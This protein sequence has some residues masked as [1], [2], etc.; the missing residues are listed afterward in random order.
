MGSCFLNEINK[1]LINDG[2]LKCEPEYG[3]HTHHEF[4]ASWGTIFSPLSAL[5]AIEYYFDKRQRPE[6]LWTSAHSGKPQVYDVFREDVVFD[7]VEEFRI[8][9]RIHKEKAKELIA[10][11]D[12]L[13]LAFSMIET[14]L[15][16]DGTEYPLAR[17]PW[18]I[19]PLAAQ[20][21]VLSYEE[22]RTT[23]NQ[24]S[25]LIHTVNPKCNVFIGVDPV[26]LHATHGTDT[27]V[28]ADSRAKAVLVSAIM[29][30]ASENKNLKYVPFYESVHY[31]CKEPWQQ[32]E[33][34]VNDEAIMK[35]YMELLVAI[36]IEDISQIEVKGQESRD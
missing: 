21:Y 9:N 36:D 35:A 3:C 19:N 15:C 8:N 22:V 26:P 5:R 1:R 30:C 10:S 17:A 12:A 14:W 33:R 13:V 34:H 11:C 6:L 23:V 2:H 29:Q 32:D 28:I 7:S 25:R 16:S 4:P 18:R 31:C 24:L 20:P 27:C